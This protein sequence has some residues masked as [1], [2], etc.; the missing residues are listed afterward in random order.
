MI[1][2]LKFQPKNFLDD[3]RRQWQ[4]ATY[5]WLLRITGGHAKFLETDLIVPTEEFF[6][7]RGLKGRAGVVTLFRR[8]RDH[9]GMADWPCTV[10]VEAGE[11]RAAGESANPEG[12]HV[13]TYRRGEFDSGALVAHF[14]RELARYLLSVS[15][16]PPPGGESRREAAVEL[17]A[18]FLGFGVFMLNAVARHAI[19]R[20]SEGEL[21]HALAL[22]C[23]LRGLPPD[24][25]DEHLNP[26]LR[27][28]V[29]LAALDL[30]QH[31]AAFKAL[32]AVIAADVPDSTLPTR[33]V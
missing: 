31:A 1:A 25:A 33:A 13:I 20:L 5:A 9:A 2:R 22:F 18:G 11:P 6:P 24:A 15:Q 21:A 4:F 14:G 23:L 17:A 16:Q 28:Y 10:E 7:D 30:A 3:S 19:F 32:R 29:R 12:L 26:H 8:V 27:K